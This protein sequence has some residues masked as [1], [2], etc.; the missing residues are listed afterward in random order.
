MPET[1]TEGSTQPDRRFQ[2]PFAADRAGYD[3]MLALSAAGKEGLEPLLLELVKTRASQLNG[4]GFCLDMHTKDARALGET[5]ERLDGLAAWRELPWYSDR[6]RAALALTEAVT[7]LS[8]GHPPAAVVEAVG[9][10]FTEP[11]AVRLLYAIVAI[12]A[13]NR[14]SIIG[15]GAAPGSYRSPHS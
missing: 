14:L 10:V 9:Q 12:N 3:A 13:W 5:D 1:L 7:R 11:E 15:T 6:E 2:I 4:C 8:E